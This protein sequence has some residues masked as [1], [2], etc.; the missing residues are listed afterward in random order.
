MHV[1]AQIKVRDLQKKYLWE[2]IYRLAEVAKD[3]CLLYG[4]VWVEFDADPIEGLTLKVLASP[5]VSHSSSIK[6]LEKD[7][8][9]KLLAVCSEFDSSC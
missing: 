7:F 6:M 5:V 2:V 9:E 1:V 8:R 3:V 4:N